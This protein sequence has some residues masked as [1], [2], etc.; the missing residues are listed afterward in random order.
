MWQHTGITPSVGSS[1]PRGADHRHRGPLHHRRPSPQST[2]SGT[3]PPRHRPGSWNVRLGFSK[4][5][6]ASLAGSRRPDFL[7]VRET[8]PLR[9]ATAVERAGAVRFSPGRRLRAGLRRAAGRPGAPRDCGL[10]EHSHIHGRRARPRGWR[11]PAGPPSRAVTP[12]RHEQRS[13]YPRAQHRAPLSATRFEFSCDGD[14]GPALQLDGHLGAPR[15]G[16][17]TPQELTLSTIR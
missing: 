6:R 12:A 14:A 2:G 16:L 17:P 1:T 7:P 4:A 15:G 10:R 8:P 5:R 11:N 9:P 13:L 3:A